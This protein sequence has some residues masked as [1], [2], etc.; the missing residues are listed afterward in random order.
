M[1]PLSRQAL[2][3][4]V[5]ALDQYQSKLMKDTESGPYSEAAKGQFEQ[6]LVRVGLVW[7]E[8]QEHYD[9]CRADHPDMMPMQELIRGYHAEEP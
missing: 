7:A 9:A 4:L 5:Q 3:T 6:Y 2:E 8:L 1:E